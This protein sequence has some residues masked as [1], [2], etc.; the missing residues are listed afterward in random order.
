MHCKLAELCGTLAQCSAPSNLSPGRFTIG[1]L[2]ASSRSTC[3]FPCGENEGV[4][5]IAN[6][7]VFMTPITSLSSIPDAF[8][9]R[10]L[11][12][13]SGIGAR[14]GHSGQSISTPQHVA[15]WLAGSWE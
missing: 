10:S 5:N 12:L 11:L 6:P 14:L 15:L 1:I 3:V 8:V 4:H 7:P 9:N 2:F 13:S